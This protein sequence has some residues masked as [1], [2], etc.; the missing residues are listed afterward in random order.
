MPCQAPAQTSTSPQRD[1][2]SGRVNKVSATTDAPATP[3]ITTH[4]KTASSEIFIPPPT[5]RGGENQVWVGRRKRAEGSALP[6]V[7]RRLATGDT[8]R[9]RFAAASED[10]DGHVDDDPHHVDEMPV[11]PW[12]LDAEVVLGGGAEVA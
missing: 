1:P 10:V 11:D 12:Y 9:R 3:T 8:P 5:Y 4:L 2:T 7:T 6:C